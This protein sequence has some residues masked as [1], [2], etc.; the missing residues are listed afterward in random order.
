MGIFKDLIVTGVGRFLSKVYASEFVGKLTG[1]ADSATK[2]TQ[3]ESGNNIKGTYATSIS[4]SGNTITLK[5][6]NGGTL[7]TIDKIATLD[8]NSKIPSS[9][10]PSYVDDVLEYSARSLFP[11][12]GETGKI[13]VDT[14]KNI[15]Y[16]WSGTTYVEI[17][18]SLALGE[19]SSTAYPGD[20]GKTAYEHSQS[21]HAPATA[22][23][24]V[25]VGIQKNGVD[26]SV[27]SNR[28]ANITVPTNVSEL[29]NDKGFI[30][31]SDNAATATTANFLKNC[32]A[33][34]NNTNT[35][36]YH[37][38]LST[39]VITYSYI[40]CSGVYE[41]TAGFDHGG[42]GIFKVDLRT[43][44]VPNGVLAGRSIE[45]IVRYGFAEDQLVVG[46]NKTS[47]NS[48]LDVYYK[49]NSAYMSVV[50]N[51]LHEGARG[52]YGNS[53]T[54]INSI[55]PA[56]SGTPTEAYASITTS[57]TSPRTYTDVITATD[58]GNV[59]YAKL[60]GSAS[61]LETS[62]VG[63]STQPVYFSNG[64]P[65]AGLS[66]YTK[67]VVGHLDWD[68]VA[69]QQRPLT[70]SA[71]AFWNGACQGADSNLVYCKRGAF[72]SIVTKS[73]DD[74]VKTEDVTEYTADDIQTMW[75]E[76]FNS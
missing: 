4:M 36:P 63:S 62:N 23:K 24:N 58:Q 10:L 45:W 31:A 7:S 18:P 28:K 57:T 74:Y 3:D 13:Y 25:I 21:P 67:N 5:N 15:T 72:G 71:I 60:A 41:I 20:R 6:K 59:R 12:V 70:K 35:Y 16:R 52:T 29:T 39:D 49:C 43:N 61:R 47:G 33:R 68:I 27:D 53:F 30:T 2:A 50:V 14:S 17:S 32:Y 51:R 48:Y 37:R 38:I 73:A 22:E 64:V 46:L 66:Y 42:Y 76:V 19:T 9:Q 75:D 44:D 34:V 56:N 1:N 55:Q 26:V 40:D 11:A 65:V 54:M 69:D 8:E